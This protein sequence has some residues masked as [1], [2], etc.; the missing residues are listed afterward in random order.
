MFLL[1]LY[2]IIYYIHSIYGVVC[3][4]VLKKYKLNTFLLYLYFA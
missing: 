4:F 3:D 1:F 2:Y